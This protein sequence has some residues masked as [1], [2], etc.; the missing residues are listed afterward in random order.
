VVVKNS[1]FS[2]TSP[3]NTANPQDV[4]AIFVTGLGGSNPA[5]QSGQLGPANPLAS[6]T[7]QPT[8]TIGGVNAQMLAAVQAPGFAGVQQVNVVVPAGLS[9]VQPVRVS[10]GGA[11]S[12]SFNVTLQ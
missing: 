10:S 2:L 12:N 1:D 4:L 8:V 9:G 11:Q 3:T 6:M 7:T 5:L